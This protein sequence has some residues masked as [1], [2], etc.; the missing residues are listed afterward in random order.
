MDR[1]S[2][3]EPTIETERVDDLPVLLAQIEKMQVTDLLGQHFVTHGNCWDGRSRLAESR[4]LT[5]EPQVE[6]CRAVDRKTPESLAELLGWEG[7]SPR[8]E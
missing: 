4:P 6:S 7:M 3:K 2:S 1:E 5:R 8:L